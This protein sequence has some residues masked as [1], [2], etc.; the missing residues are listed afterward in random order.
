VVEVDDAE[1]VAVRIGQ[2]DHADMSMDPPWSN[3][4]G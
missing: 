3:L 1:P 4:A 2:H